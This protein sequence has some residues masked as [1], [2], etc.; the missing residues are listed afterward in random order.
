[1]HNSILEAIQVS[2]I[3]WPIHSDRPANTGTVNLTDNHDVAYELVKVCRDNAP[4]QLP[5]ARWT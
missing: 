1:M 4:I 5:W 2:A 3:C